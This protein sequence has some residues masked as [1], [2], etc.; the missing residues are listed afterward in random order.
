MSNFYRVIE[1]RILLNGEFSPVVQHYQGD[2]TVTDPETGVEYT[3]TARDR[4][5]SRYHEICSA[6]ARSVIPYH[7]VVLE[8]EDNTVLESAYWDRRQENTA[9]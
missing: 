3:L 9:E 5:L 6:A 7:A 8:M 2:E 1:D 4:A